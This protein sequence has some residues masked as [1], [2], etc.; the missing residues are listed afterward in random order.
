MSAMLA[1]CGFVDSGVNANIPPNQF[2]DA[3]QV[4]EGGQLDVSAP[5]ILDNDLDGGNRA[6]TA[7]LRT[8]PSHAT[9]FNL[10]EDGSFTYTHNGGELPTD[11]FTYIASDGIADSEPA[12][13]TISI[14]PVNDPPVAGDDDPIFD[15][16]VGIATG[17]VLANDTDP[18]N[19]S[20]Q[21]T[22]VAVNGSSTSPITGNWGTLSWN[23]DGTYEYAMDPSVQALKPTEFVQDSFTYTIQDQE[24]LSDSATLTI[25]IT[26]RNDAPVAQPDSGFEV[27]EGGMLSVAAA[28]GVL[29]ND[30]DVEGDPLSAVLVTNPGNASSFSLGATG[31]FSYQHNGGETTSDVFT[32]QARDSDQ[33]LSN[34]TTV[35]ITVIPV[36]DPPNAV[37]DSNS[38]SA[39]HILIP[40]TGDMRANDSDP[41]DA[42]STL[43]ISEVNGSSASPQSGSWVDLSWQADGGYS[44]TMRPNVR[45]LK[46]G[47]TVMDTFAYT[48]R[49]PQGATDGATLTFTI[50]GVNDPPTATDD[51]AVTNEDTAVT[52]DV[53]AND[54][55]PE[56]DA[57]TIQAVTQGANG[58]VTN[59]GTDVTYTPNPDFNGSDSFTYSVTDSISGS[60]TATVNVTVNPVNDPPVAVADFASTSLATATT[61]SVLANDTDPDSGDTRSVESVTQP[62]N[63]IV[64]NNG[65]NVTY[66]PNDGFVGPDLFSYRAQDLSGALSN[67]A[68]VTVT[69]TLARGI[70]RA[71]ADHGVV[72]ED[73]NV[74]PARFSAGLRRPSNDSGGSSQASGNLLAN[75]EDDQDAPTELTLTAINDSGHSPVRGTY[76]TV[77]W[78]SNGDYTYTVDDADPDTDAL[79]EGATGYDEFGYT[80]RNSDGGQ[81]L[82]TLIIAVHGKNDPP[83]AVGSCTSTPQAKPVSRQLTA[84]D[85]DTDVNSLS[86]RLVPGGEPAKGTVAIEAG[87]RY[88]YTPSN[89]GERGRDQFQFEV[90]DGLGGIATGVETVIVANRVMPLGDSFTRGWSEELAGLAESAQGGGYRRPL[91]EALSAEGYAVDFVGTRQDG[92]A[93]G[94]FDVDHEGLGGATVTQMATDVSAWLDANPPDIILLQIGGDQFASGATPASSEVEDLLNQI[95]LWMQSAGGNAARVLL[96]RIPD[97]SPYD[98]RIRSFNDAVAAM[99]ATR[100]SAQVVPVDLEGSLSYPGDL[101]DG[102]HLNA[103]GY[104][105]MAEAWRDAL[106]PWLS[107]CP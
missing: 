88:T 86:Y 60:D 48:L 97:Q 70:P 19:P 59:S 42:Q 36:N 75:D 55:D 51:D 106:A 57:L 96:A 73:A 89:P 34:P 80:V 104:A 68:T 24:P 82:G 6:L 102:V 45:S 40:I 15:E 71:N 81:A 107:K 95:D 14:D 52:I 37:N 94:G 49:D 5:G 22:L 67:F 87:G 25:T 29:T 78:K 53:L 10:N 16:D 83:L 32:Y 41:D 3:F 62:G 50:F 65:T 100:N 4:A 26:G 91:W 85:V 21:L 46:P 105:R 30:T 72:G 1:A 99:A 76:G 79:A 92:D 43:A 35:T 44:A 12:T 58:T 90:D 28:N 56:E 33:A 18:D 47:D 74:E 101:S 103:E 77:E 20:S 38:A 11:K 23:A 17:D 39:E 54:E 93:P 2:D 31:G 63:G 64:V 66:T 61:I 84:T 9:A 8:G 27:L 13:V 69:V 7:R 98:G